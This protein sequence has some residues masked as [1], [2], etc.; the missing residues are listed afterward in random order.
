[1]S[2]RERHERI[3]NRVEYDKRRT[4]DA[5]ETQK[6]MN[7]AQRRAFAKAYRRQLKKGR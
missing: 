1:M 6:P 5:A 4:E 3:S 7:R 2:D